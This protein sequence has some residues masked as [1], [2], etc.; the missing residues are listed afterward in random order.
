[1]T[2]DKEYRNYLAALAVEWKRAAKAMPSEL[3][4]DRN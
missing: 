4:A 3:G 1:M 2:P